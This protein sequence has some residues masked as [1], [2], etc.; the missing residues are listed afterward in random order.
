[1][2][3]VLYLRFVRLVPLFPLTVQLESCMVFPSL[4]LKLIYLD[5]LSIWWLC[6]VFCLFVLGRELETVGTINRHFIG[7][8]LILKIN[9][10]LPAANLNNF[11]AMLVFC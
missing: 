7:E 11:I 2:F 1:M 9:S 3:F 5:H 6:S 8:R 10:N 4:V